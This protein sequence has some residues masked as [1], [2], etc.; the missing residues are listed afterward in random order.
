VFDEDDW[1]LLSGAFVVGRVMRDPASP[2]H[3]APIGNHGTT[4]TLDAS[5]AE[6]MAAW[7]REQM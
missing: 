7:R 5:Q 1:L 3:G 2:Q 6:L 4:G